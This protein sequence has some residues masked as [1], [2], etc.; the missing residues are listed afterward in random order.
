VRDIRDD[1]S[2][3]CI[4]LSSRNVSDVEKQLV[5]TE[6]SYSDLNLWIEFDVFFYKWTVLAIRSSSFEHWKYS[7]KSMYHLD[8][9]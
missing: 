4:T 6:L 1:V 2:V 9:S 5:T 8:Y 7:G 3:F